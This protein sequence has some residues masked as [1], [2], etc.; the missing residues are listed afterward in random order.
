VLSVLFTVVYLG[1]AIPAIAAGVA[2]V[3][4]GGLV[5]TSYEYCVAVI[6]LAVAATINLVRLPSTT[7]PRLTRS[8]R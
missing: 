2:V 6:V 5:A 3:R 8:S 4:A 1:L 7:T